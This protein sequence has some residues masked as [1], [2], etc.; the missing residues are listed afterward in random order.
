MKSFQEAEATL[1][2]NSPAGRLTPDFDRSSA[3]KSERADSSKAS[4][5]QSP[6]SSAIPSKPSKD[7]VMMKIRDS[8]T[9][10][11]GHHLHRTSDDTEMSQSKS[12][13]SDSESR[14]I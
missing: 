13:I 14:M 5:S 12:R 3:P 9:N 2:V 6:K 4:G 7:S 11:E 10:S 1:A 8:L